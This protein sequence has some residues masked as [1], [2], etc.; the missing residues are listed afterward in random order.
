MNRTKIIIN[1]DNS[2][3]ISEKKEKTNRKK[4]DND[5]IYENVDNNTFI[6]GE[7]GYKRSQKYN[8]QYFMH[9]WP[10]GI[11]DSSAFGEFWVKYA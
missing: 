7:E 4:N 11:I 3:K 8:F 1:I 6:Y 2:N 5:K 9:I 10:I